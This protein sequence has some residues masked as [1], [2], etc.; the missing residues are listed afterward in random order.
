MI[1]TALY[2]YYQRKSAADAK[3]LARPGFEF[4]EIPF[5]IV[6][7]DAGRFVQ[8]AD[9]REGEGKKKRAKAIRVPQGI[10]KTS[11]VAANLLWDSAEY[12]LGVDTRGKPARVAQQHQAFR[13]R[14]RAAFGDAPDDPGLA[15]VYRFLEG[16]D[17]AQLGAQTEWEEIRQTNPPLT[18]KLAGDPGPV[19]ERPVVEAAVEATAGQAAD[20]LCLVSGRADAIARLHPAIKGVRGAQ[21]S[22]ANILSFN[23]DAFNSYGK[24]Q[25]ANAPVGER[26][27]FAYTTA[28]N[29]LLSRNSR[30]KLQLG[31]AVTLVFW[32]EK[33]SGASVEN[34]LSAWFGPPADNPDA[35]TQAVR[36]LYEFKRGQPLTDDD[37]QRFF[38]LGLS[39]NNARLSVCLWSIST[40]AE[41]GETIFRHFQDLQIVHREQE[42][43]HLSLYRLLV[44]VAAQE[45]LDNLPPN[46]AS[47]WLRTI[48]AGPAVP[49][50]ATLFQAAMRRVRAERHISYPRAALIKACL[51][52]YYRRHPDA[53]PGNTW[54]EIHVMLDESLDDVGY[55]LGRLF[56]VLEQ[57]QI[58]AI[59]E[60]KRENINASIRD[61]YYGAASANPVAVYPVLMRLYPHHIAKLAKARAG[62]AW[63][64]E[65]L[66]DAI[67][68]L[69][70]ADNP[71]P[72]R[73]SLP[74]QGCFA[75]GYYQ[76]RQAYFTAKEAAPE[77]DKE[78]QGET[79]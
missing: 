25:G 74:Q 7:D 68:N 35:N 41:L 55:L 26:A 24:A 58:L 10:K 1:L 72:H 71:F 65:K 69:L 39:P 34:A 22:G 19:C 33:A 9:L 59:T 66:C 4:K 27:A 21:S 73:L 13:E 51:N 57:A 78:T 46:L 77:Q 42:P 64:L 43:E 6:I 5:W 23:L 56:F 50:P 54:R 28:L 67:C 32:A 17:L 76:Q 36:A 16:L 2:D 3:S 18:F 40:V 62:S 61:R 45:K 12:V 79:P 11:G 70:P 15:A 60:G 44:S 29:H 30:Q 37:G 48:L 8:F 49:Y 75:V 14:L 63:R 52:R 47:A 38:V 53:Y 31:E 20:G